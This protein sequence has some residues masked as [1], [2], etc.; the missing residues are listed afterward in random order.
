[1]GE[2]KGPL[3]NGNETEGLERGNNR[4]CKCIGG[5]TLEGGMMQVGAVLGGAWV[6]G[7]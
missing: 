7:A 6:R 2:L 4:D 5:M 1:M 3:E